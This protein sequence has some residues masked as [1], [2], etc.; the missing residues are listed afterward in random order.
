MWDYQPSAIVST[1]SVVTAK[2]NGFRFQ[3][4]FLAKA[5][6]PSFLD[7]TGSL[8]TFVLHLGILQRRI[9]IAVAFRSKAIGRELK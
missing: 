5:F 1:R 9:L 8:V 2:I 4:N 7:F 6:K 3:Q